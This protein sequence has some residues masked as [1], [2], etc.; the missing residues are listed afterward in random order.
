MRC[1][2]VVRAWVVVALRVQTCYRK[3]AATGQHV[4]VDRHNARGCHTANFYLCSLLVLL[5]AGL[6]GFSC[7]ACLLLHMN[8]CMSSGEFPWCVCEVLRPGESVTVSRAANLYHAS[9][10]ARK[11]GKRGR[12]RYVVGS[13]SLRCTHSFRL[14]HSQKRPGAQLEPSQRK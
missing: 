5:Y 6:D 13:S 8:A 3:I 7:V 14:P 9:M 2:V 1:L 4:T 11:A 12:A 10:K